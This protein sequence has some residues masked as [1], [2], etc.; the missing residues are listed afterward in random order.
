MNAMDLICGLNNVQDSYVASAEAFRQ[1]KPKGLPK[2]KL[3]LI[4]ALIALTLL[5]VG[6]AV[7][8]V[9]RLQ[10]L[11]VGEYRFYV[12][13]A[14]DENGEVIPVE[15]RE[16]FTVLSVQGS[17]MEALAEWVA[18]TNAYDLDGTIALEADLAAKSASSAMVPSRS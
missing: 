4:A 11:K 9:L 5:L 14:Y 2:R 3:W 7:V 1:Q 8:Y 18:F 16:P 12:P 17:N 15:T 13:A 10:D 6:C